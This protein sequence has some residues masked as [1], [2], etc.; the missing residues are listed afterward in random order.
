MHVTQFETYIA[1]CAEDVHSERRL[2]GEVHGVSSGGNVM[3]GEQCA[4]AEFEIRRDASMPL[5]IPLQA[6]GIEADAIGRVRGLENKKDRNASTAYS[7]RPRRKLGSAGRSVST[8]AQSGIE[9]A[10]YCRVLR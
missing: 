9:G 3:V 4:A 8:V 5:E 2:V 1:F 7:N 10:E 6:E